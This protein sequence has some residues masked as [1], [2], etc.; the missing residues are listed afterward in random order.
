MQASGKHDFS[1][2]IFSVS[3]KKFWPLHEYGTEDVMRDLSR[4]AHGEDTICAD[5][6]VKR[7][8]LWSWTSETVVLIVKRGR[9][10][11]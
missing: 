3:L 1:K 2:E 4:V 7:G 9:R 6:D 10:L 8:R 11:S 5:S